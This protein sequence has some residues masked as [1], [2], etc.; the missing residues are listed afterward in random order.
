MTGRHW[1]V[2]LI[3]RDAVSIAPVSPRSQRSY[4]MMSRRQFIVHV[5]EGDGLSFDSAVSQ[6]RL[7]A[8]RSGANGDIEVKSAETINLPFEIPT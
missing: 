6:A 7:L 2:V 8:R 5:P 1:H 4:T 3:C